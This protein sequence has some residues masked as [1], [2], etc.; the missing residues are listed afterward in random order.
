M[1]GTQKSPLFFTAV[2]VL[3]TVTAVDIVLVVC[4]IEPA[5]YARLSLPVHVPYCHCQ[6]RWN[7]VTL[8]CLQ[9]LAGS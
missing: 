5:F 3:V 7:H 9:T 1:L 2:R 8:P 4:V 6:C